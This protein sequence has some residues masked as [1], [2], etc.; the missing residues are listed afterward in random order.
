MR[1]QENS[2]QTVCNG[3]IQQCIF[4]VMFSLDEVRKRIV[5][6]AVIFTA[7]VFLFLL[8][9]FSFPTPFYYV[10]MFSFPW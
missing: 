1:R 6:F 7:N 10:P 4:A 2:L 9:S 3:K 5:L 8:A